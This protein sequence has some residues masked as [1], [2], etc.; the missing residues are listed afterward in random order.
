MAKQDKTPQPAPPNEPSYTAEASVDF[1]NSSNNSYVRSQGGREA[2]EQFRPNEVIPDCKTQ[3]DQRKIMAMSNNFYKRNGIVRSVI[4][5]QSEIAVAGLSLMSNDATTAAFYQAWE[6]RVGLRD[7]AEQF[8]RWYLRCN[9]VV[10]HRRYGKLK[11]GKVPVNYFFYDPSTIEA[12]GGFYGTMGDV[13]LYGIKVPVHTYANKKLPTNGDEKSVFDSYPIEI[14]KM[15]K[16][17]SDTNSPTYIKLK[18]EDIYV[19]HY[20]KDDTLVWAVPFLYSLFDDLFYNQKLKLTKITMLDGC[21]APVALWKLGDHKEGLMPSPALG[22]KLLDIEQSNTGGGKK[23]FIWD[24]AV[25]Y[26]E[27]YPPIDKIAGYDEKIDPILWGLGIQVYKSSSTTGSLPVGLKD[28]IARIKSCRE[29]ISVWLETEF[30]IIRKTMG[31]RKNPSIVFDY[32]DLYDDKIYWNFIKELVDRNVISDDRVR[33]MINENSE[34]E[35]YRI[36]QDEAKRNKEEMP[37]KASPFHNP[38]LKMQQ[39]HELKKIQSENLVKEKPSGKPG[40][41]PVGSRD[42]MPRVVRAS[43]VN[44]VVAMKIYDRVDKMTQSVMMKEFDITDARQLTN[45]QKKNIFDAKMV[46]YASVHPTQELTDEALAACLDSSVPSV[47]DRFFEL[48]EQYSANSGINKFTN[49]E[50][51]FILVQCYCEAWNETNN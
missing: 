12:I 16:G 20:K 32:A 1:Y 37:Q 39:E 33:E 17:Q 35:R 10:V 46:L 48:F 36:A 29:A 4:D 11:R 5:L 44:P 45:E 13:K 3:D 27:F 24:S 26:E 34:I 15:L 2:Y 47:F 9:N 38:L 19:G 43:V 41:R 25:S 40:G 42:K 23:T 50:L 30:D 14:Q 22:V 6:K 18:P 28:F 51:K 8:A 31:F 7:R 49:D 21:A